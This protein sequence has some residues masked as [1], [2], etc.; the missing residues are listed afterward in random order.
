MLFFKRDMS[1]KASKDKERLH[2]TDLTLH[3]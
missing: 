2:T 3:S 1:I